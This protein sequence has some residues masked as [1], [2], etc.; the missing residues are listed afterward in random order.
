ML[1][2]RRVETGAPRK[3]E[4]WLKYDFPG[5]AREGMKYSSLKW[6]SEHFSGTDWDQKTQRNAIYKV[7]DDPAT[8]PKPSQEQLSVPSRSTH[9]FNRVAKFAKQAVSNALQEFSEPRDVWKRPG[10]GWAEDVDKLHGN[11]DYLMFSNVYYAHPE[12]R[13]DVLRWGE[14]MVHETG[15]HGFRLDAAQHIPRNFVRE[16][17][18]RVQESSIQQH[19]RDV[20]IVGEVWSPK[21][22]GL[23]EWLDTVTPPGSP[24]LAH[25]FDTPLLYSFSRVSEDVRKGSR[26]A[27]LRTLLTGPGHSGKQALI[28]LRPK[29]AITFCSNHDTQA[30]QSSYTP[31][32]STIKSLFYAFILLRQ[33][34]HPSVFWG[35]LYGTLGDR[36]QGPACQV[37]SAS[38]TSGIRSVLP[39]LMLARK[40][41]AYG[42]QRDYI[43][44]MSCIGW[45]RAGTFDRPGCVVVISIGSAGKWT[46]KKMAAGRPGERWIDILSEEEG[47]P[48]IVIDDDGCG[49]F[50]CRGMGVCVYVNADVVDTNRFPTEFDH[51][52]YR[53]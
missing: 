13:R 24:V 26:N 30:G 49:V 7:I 11:Y 18:A 10:K 27:D 15:V 37:P 19:G 47:R 16:W 33:E 36:A 23:L 34:G 6:T 41:F 45:T 46:I 42:A 3:I 9:G 53:Q 51:D 20:F 12:V 48:E 14:W 4:A 32:E 8:Y 44:S 25:A 38:S 22:H 39:S 29:Q 2:D 40:L 17:I 50:A 35:D 21:A 5:R 28:T 52:A 1:L 31:M 43:D